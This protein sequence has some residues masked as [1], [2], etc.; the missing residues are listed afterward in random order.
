MEASQGSQGNLIAGAGGV[1]LIILLFLPWVSVEGIDNPSGWEL[2]RLGDV[3]FLIAGVVAIGAA[4]SAGGRLLP[5]LSLNGAASLL[6]GVATIL[7]L[8]LLIFDWP[9]QTSRTIWVFLALIAAGAIA[10]GGSSAAQDEGA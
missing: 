3:Y 8:W 6:G 7:I 4:V 9:D 2:F 5:G 1:A 10:F